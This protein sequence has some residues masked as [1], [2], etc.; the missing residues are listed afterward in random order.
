MLKVEGLCP[1]HQIR[2]GH[3]GNILSIQRRVHTRAHGGNCPQEGVSREHI[4]GKCFSVPGEQLCVQLS[5]TP[6]KECPAMQRRNVKSL[7]AC[8][9]LMKAQTDKLFPLQAMLCTKASC[10]LEDDTEAWSAPQGVCESG[11]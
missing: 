9:Y 8:K 11:A 10:R 5:I 3:Q 7:H 4:L 6:L 2:K 1:A